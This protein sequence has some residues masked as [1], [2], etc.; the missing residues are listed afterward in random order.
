MSQQLWPASLVV[1]VCV[2]ACRVVCVKAKSLFFASLLSGWLSVRTHNNLW[3]VLFFSQA[4]SFLVSL[5]DAAAAAAFAG[6]S[7]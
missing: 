7:G 3:S 5:V 1:G 4:G 2:F 6:S